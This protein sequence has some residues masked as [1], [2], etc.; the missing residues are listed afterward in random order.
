M[1]TLQMRTREIAKAM[2]SSFFSNDHAVTTTNDDDER[3]YWVGDGRL[4]E[5][6]TLAAFWQ[7]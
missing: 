1:A 3:N 6:D 2:I 7:C 5:A 4:R